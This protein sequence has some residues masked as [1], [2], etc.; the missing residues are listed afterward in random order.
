MTSA[1]RLEPG[2]VMV[3]A[4]AVGFVTGQGAPV[5]DATV[6]RA[7]G[8]KAPV[9]PNVFHFARLTELMLDHFGDEWL[10]SGNVEVRYSSF[11]YAGDTLIPKA[12]VIA[13]S[14][15]GDGRRRVAMEVW[16]ENQD[17]AVL[18]SGT[19]ECLPRA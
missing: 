11:L 13:V 7:S 16:C 6:A 5:Q 17:G 15:D 19:A 10:T 3:G 18:A 8:L 9:V 12:Q 14:E 2:D 4:P 1:S